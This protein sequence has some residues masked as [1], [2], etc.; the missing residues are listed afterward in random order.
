MS[1]A[2]VASVKRLGYIGSVPGSKDNDRDSDSWYTPAEYIE[3]ARTAMGCIDLDPFSSEEA[4]KVVKANWFYTVED[5]AL[6]RD[7]Y[8]KTRGACVW[9]NPPYS[10]NM[11]KKAIAAFLQAY[12]SGYI[13][14]GIVLV[15]NATDTKWFHKMRKHCSAACFTDHRIAFISPDGKR[16]SGNTRGQCFMYFG[17]TEGAKAFATSFSNLGWVVESYKEAR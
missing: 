10:G 13:K 15:N 3:A 12:E 17:D 2:S 7:W 8:V 6:S 4:N 1:D 16:V 11:V 5:D 14:R 9:M